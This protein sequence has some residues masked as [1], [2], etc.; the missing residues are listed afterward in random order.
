ML[1]KDHQ[2][3]FR[4]YLNQRIQSPF[5]ATLNERLSAAPERADLQLE[6]QPFSGPPMRTLY[7]QHLVKVLDDASFAAVPVAEIDKRS[8]N[9]Q[10][11]SLE[12]FGLNLLNVAS[13]FVPGLGEAMLAVAASQLLQA[14]I[15]GIDDWTHQDREHAVEGLSGVVLNLAV[16]GGITLVSHTFAGASLI[17][18]LPQVKLSPGERRLWRP[19]LGAYEQTPALPPSLLPDEAGVYE[20]ARVRY[21]KRDAKHYAAQL[22][23]TSRQGHINYPGHPERYSLKLSHNG[24]GAWFHELESPLHWQGATLVQ[25][26]G[27]QAADFSELTA[28]RILTVSG[29][30]EAQLRRMHFD[31]QRP[32]ALLADTVT[33]FQLDADIQR[34]IERLQQGLDTPDQSM[35]HQVLMDLWRSQS[36]VLQLVDEQGQRLMEVPEGAASRI[37]RVQISRSQLDNGDLLK[38]VLASKSLSENDIRA[39]LGESPSVGDPA[40]RPEVRLLT[41]RRK[42]AEQAQRRRA[43]LFDSQYQYRTQSKAPSVLLIQKAFPELPSAIAQELVDHAI[44]AQLQQLL[45]AQTV[46]RQLA[47]EARAYLPQ[48][49]EARA[50]EGLY[51]DS[52]HSADAQKMLLHHFESLP[53]WSNTVRIEVRDDSIDGPLIDSIGPEQAATRKVL[54]REKGKYETRD[55]R[56][57]SLHGV[58]DLYSSVL[59]ALPDKERAALGFADT[60]QGAQLKAQVRQQPAMSRQTLAALLKS[61]SLEA[62]PPPLTRQR[63]GYPLSGRGAPQAAK[64]WALEDRVKQLYPSFTD[65]Q[66]NQFIGAFAGSRVFSQIARL[67]EE[68]SNLSDDLEVWSLITSAFHPETGSLLSLTERANQLRSRQQFAQAIKRCWRR[69]LDPGLLPEETPHYYTL[70]SDGLLGELP[71]LP[72]DFEHVQGLNL[73]L[74][75]L[76]SGAEQ[77]LARFPNVTRLSVRGLNL[78]H[79]P[80]SILERTTLI[81]LSV[82][83]CQLKLDPA[84]VVTLS[85]LEQLEILDLSDNPL[86]LTPNL[87][88]IRKLAILDLSNTGITA[89]PGGLLELPVLEAVDLSGNAIELLPESIGEVAGDIS[90]GFDFANNPF[91]DIS[92][93]RARDYYHRTGNSLG[94]QS[95]QEREQVQALLPGLAEENLEDF[96]RALPNRLNESFEYLGTLQAELIQMRADLD[97]WIDETPDTH[98]RTGEQLTANERIEDNYHRT[99]FAETLLHCWKRHTYVTRGHSTHYVLSF[100][101]KMTGSLPRL[102]ADFSHVRELDIYGYGASGG[103]GHF[104]GHFHGLQVLNAP[105]FLD[106][107]LPAALLHMSKLTSLNLTDGSIVLTQASAQQL[108]QMHNL[109][110]LDLANN[111]LGIAPDLTQLHQLDMLDL[112]SCELIEIPEG[113]FGLEALGTAD[114]RHNEI[115]V[116]PPDLR[117]VPNTRSV[118]YD[119]RGNPLDALSQRRVDAY[120]AQQGNNGLVSVLTGDDIVDME[121]IEDII[122]MDDNI[123]MEDSDSQDSISDSESGSDYIL[124]D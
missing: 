22:N 48:V 26:L 101:A 85:H 28:Q 60:N 13:L 31:S 51:L 33:R 7:T 41:L 117:E 121:D 42:I 92:L 3:F 100:T 87:S 83:N 34:F 67:E 86:G 68:Y 79:L 96:L 30:D 84:A 71:E 115:T 29:V 89:I 57:Q 112:N 108:S 43:P 2:R 64:A 27:P 90:D 122:E 19:D 8:W 72:T 56:D 105:G 113:L 81:E 63:L 25:R 73:R 104:L 123:E 75:T 99:L 39:L 37:K 40:D 97:F 9:D 36:K 94:M 77:F 80:S 54:I 114:L 74:D 1:N 107:S 53:G 118:I 98:P 15:H 61:P 116:I 95:A 59:H 50:L 18:E 106:E 49:R 58:D 4:R 110:L 52:V 12:N 119:F 11:Q 124:E 10:V 66:V 120:L 78:T 5:L 45:Q 70:S 17:K 91:S 62:P 44:G 20:Y 23:K 16:I 38:A 35:Q 103:L 14:V 109:Q 6:R 55:E 111:P 24:A 102:S 21:L 76:T 32:P 88:R 65:A 82:V 69:E 46:P 47:A 93:Q